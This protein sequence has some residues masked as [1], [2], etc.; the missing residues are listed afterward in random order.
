[1]LA[2]WLK[3]KEPSNIYDILVPKQQAPLVCFETAAESVF[4]QSAERHLTNGLLT[5]VS[6]Y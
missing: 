3:S 4:S 2:Y 1:M 5:A 6:A